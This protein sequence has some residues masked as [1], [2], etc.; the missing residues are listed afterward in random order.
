[1][2]KIIKRVLAVVIVLVI[3][4]VVIFRQENDGKKV[5]KREYTVGF[6][7]HFMEDDYTVNVVDA[8]EKKMKEEGV[9][10]IV[11]NANGDS[12]KQVADIEDL[13]N[14]GVDAIGICPLDESAIKQSL[15]KAQEKGIKVVTITEIPGFQADAV[16]YGRE[17]ENG[18]GSGKRLVK[19]LE[20]EKNAE[21][22]VLDFPYGVERMKVRIEGFEAALENTGITVAQI[23]RPATNEEAME[24]IRNELEENPNIKGI[25]GSYSNQVIGAGAACKALD[26]KDIVVVGVDADLKVLKLMQEGWVRAVTAQFPQEHGEYCAVAI[27]DKLENRQ[28][29]ERYEAPYQIVDS[30]NATQMAKRL[31]NKDL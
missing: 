6:S 12:K 20:G 17:Y 26:R 19:A 16:V 3:L 15:M 1:M 5:E 22:L 11:V 31:W 10:T 27:I 24:Y 29:M 8:F 18:Y 14:Q 25:F 9:E 13:I 4:L 7:I 2:K 23:G 30:G 21:V 28:S